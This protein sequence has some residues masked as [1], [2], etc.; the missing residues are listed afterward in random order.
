[1]RHILKLYLLF[2]FSIIISSCSEQP[3]SP[4]NN[5]TAKDNISVSAELSP[6]EAEGIIYM[7]QEEKIA[8]DVYTV[9]G[10]TWN[11]NIFE[12]IKPSEQNHMD[13]MKNLITRYNLEDPVTIDSVGFFSNP[14]FQQKYDDF[15]QQGQQSL[16]EALIVG[17]LIEEEDIAALENQLTFVDN[18]DIIMVYTHLKSASGRHLNAFQNHSSTSSS[19]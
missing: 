18:Q 3:T 14:D 8:R 7:R 12:K 13:K 17:Q 15:V 10:Q 4:N 6:E 5:S 11:A 16:T 19:D 2:I 9:L 1:M